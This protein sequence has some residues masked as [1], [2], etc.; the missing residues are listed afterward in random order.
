MS[1]IIRLKYQDAYIIN[2]ADD[3]FFL[4]N[5]QG[6]VM[7]YEQVIEVANGLINFANNHKEELHFTN[8]ENK[9]ELEKEFSKMISNNN[10]NNH[11]EEKH[12]YLLECGGKYKIGISSDVNR[13][14][15]ELDKRPFKIN[16]LAKSELT[17]KAY[18]IEQDLHHQYEKNRING[19][20][21]ELTDDDIKEIKS[22]ILNMTK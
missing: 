20:W 3:G 1:K 15:K 7:E 11:L 10:N 17:T 14:I 21:Y 2:E 5:G 9:K 22:I 8:I 12:I 16:I 4:S 6:Y 18:K 13:R 19:E